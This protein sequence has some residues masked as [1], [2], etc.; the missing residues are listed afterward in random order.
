LEKPSNQI[1]KG[2]CQVSFVVIGGRRDTSNIPEVSLP[3]VE[4]ISVE[5]KQQDERGALNEPFSKEKLDS[6]VGHVF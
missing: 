4:F 2:N 3:F 5:V 6:M 1:A